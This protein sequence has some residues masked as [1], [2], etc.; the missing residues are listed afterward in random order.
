[1]IRVK[2]KINSIPQTIRRLGLDA[3]GD[4]QRFHT[5]NVLRRIKKYMPYISGSLYK[6]TVAQTDISK[7][8]IVTE[9]PQAGYLFIGKK[10]VNAK[11]G[12]GPALIPG[13]GFRYKRGTI[14]MPT[15][16]PLN[17][18]KT[19]NSHAGPRWD[20]TLVAREGKAMVADVQKYV[21]RRKR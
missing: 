5:N 18:T 15:N 7:P 1:M 21:D 11:T 14:L 4:V 19:K 10:M 6:M 13:V 8:L 2:L 16:I 20:R 3:S 9:A 12:K 17:Y